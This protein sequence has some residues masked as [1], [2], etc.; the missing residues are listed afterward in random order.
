ME[1]NI[2]S[3]AGSGIGARIES[4]AIYLNKFDSV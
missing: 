2:F 1:N 3:S 4:K